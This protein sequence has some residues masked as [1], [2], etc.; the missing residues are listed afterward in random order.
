[1]LADEEVC[2]QSLKSRVS[3][4]V[5]SY[6]FIYFLHHPLSP[7]PN[8]CWGRLICLFSYK[9]KFCFIKI[10]VPSFYPMFSAAK[11]LAS[12]ADLLIRR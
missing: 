1:M 3:V 5:C 11:L 7:I 12:C 4:L 8:I 6:V 9:S 2:S 10:W